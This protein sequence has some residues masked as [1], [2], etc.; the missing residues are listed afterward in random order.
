MVCATS[1]ALTADPRLLYFDEPV[2]FSAFHDLAVYRAWNDPK[3]FV[4]LPTGVRSDKGNISFFYR[5]NGRG[6]YEGTL[7]L[8]IRP[9]YD[10]PE[11]KAVLDELKTTVPDGHFVV[12]EPVMSEWEVAG[13]GVKQ[14]VTPP[15][16]SN[17]LLANTSVTLTISD[18]LTRILLHSGSNYASAFVVRHKFAVRGIELDD[19]MSPKITTRWF[20]RSVSLPG[21]CNIEPEKYVDFRTGRAG[22]IFTIIFDRRFVLDVQA[23]LK[24]INLY[25]GPLDGVAGVN[26]RAAIRDFQSSH[27]MDNDGEVSSLLLLRLRE[28]AQMSPS[29][30]V[31][32]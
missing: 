21:G 13:I 18:E 16:M 3:S 4:I 27:G 1:P 12:G 20:S 24:K 7:Q 25:R 26:T 17:P 15:L 22:C 8:T 6:L 10:D 28:A 9:G 32:N 23:L 31:A 2:G 14:T 30:A 29:A 5:K 19:T 11:L